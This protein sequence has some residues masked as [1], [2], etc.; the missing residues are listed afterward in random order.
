MKLA[1]A[2]FLLLCSGILFLAG[3]YLIWER[4]NPYHASAFTGQSPQRISGQPE[5]LTIP[6][7]NISLPIY[8]AKITG[9]RWEQTTKGISFLST[10]ALPGNAGN[11]ILYGHNWPNLLGPL[12]KVKPGQKVYVRYGTI[13]HSF[14]IHYVGVVNG[15]DVS[16]IAPTSD[17]RLTLYTCTGFLDQKRLVVTALRDDTLF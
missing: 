9:N 17:V 1:F 7:V 15:D 4:T 5:S 10:S 16:V 14:T 8:P 2:K 13:T 6:S 3:V 12:H 11:S